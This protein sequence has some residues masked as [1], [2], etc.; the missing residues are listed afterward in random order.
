MDGPRL[1]ICSSI[2]GHLGCFCFLAIVNN[3]AMNFGGL[4]LL[5]EPLLSILLGIHLEVDLLDHMVTL[6]NSWRHCQTV[7]LTP[8][9]FTS[10]VSESGPTGFGYRDCYVTIRTG[11]R[12]QTRKRSSPDTKSAGTPIFD[13][14]D[15]RTKRNKCQLKKRG[16]ASLVAQWLRICLPM[17]GTRVR[18]LVWEDPTCRGAT[19]PLSHSY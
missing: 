16:G 18:A 1:F 6:F 8:N 2:G 12:L 11:F 17:Q 14:S 4:T 19:R 5:F 13:F 3:P 15:S 10:T 7:F 9:G